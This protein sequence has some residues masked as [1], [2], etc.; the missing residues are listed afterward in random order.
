M[1][2]RVI[3][4]YNNLMFRLPICLLAAVCI[5]L[6]NTPTGLFVAMKY[7]IFYQQVIQSFGVAFLLTQI[8]HSGTLLLDK[9]FDW[10]QKPFRR[11]GLQATFGILLPVLI[12]YYIMLLYFNY[13]V[14]KDIHT[15]RY[16]LIYFPHIVYFIIL[17]NLYY[18]IHNLVARSVIPLPPTAQLRESDIPAYTT[19]PAIDIPECQLPE[20][21]S[22]VPATSGTTTNFRKPDQQ[23]RNGEEQSLLDNISNVCFFYRYSGKNRIVYMDGYSTITGLS[24]DRIEELTAISSVSEATQSFFRINRQVLLSTCAFDMT[25]IQLSTRQN[26]IDI[27]SRYLSS[28]KGIVPELFRIGRFNLEKFKWW[29]AQQ[30]LEAETTQSPKSRKPA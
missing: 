8:T 2:N 20:Y 12:A 14:G 22:R 1:K 4:R 29:L 24:L 5:T 27:Y 7:G 6:Y 17:I 19:I 3:V 9:H 28:S 25:G 13:F 16:M 10:F 21:S 18:V 15:S 30:H 11:G 26:Q 23:Q